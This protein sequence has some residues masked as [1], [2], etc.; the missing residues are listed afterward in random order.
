M[1]KLLIFSIIFLSLVGTNCNAKKAEEDTIKTFIGSTIKNGHCVHF[2][3]S[4]NNI[5]M[6]V[7]FKSGR[8]FNSLTLNNRKQQSI[9]KKSD[10]IKEVNI[11]SKIY[12]NTTIV[13]MNSKLSCL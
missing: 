10:V 5:I 13:D 1:K 8:A 12:E 7:F 6:E 11:I 3:R 2:Y 4:Q 9:R